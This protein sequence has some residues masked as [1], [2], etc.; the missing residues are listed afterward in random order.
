[1]RRRVC[2]PWHHLLLGYVDYYPNLTYLTLG[3]TYLV[4]RA[5]LYPE[6]TTQLPWLGPPYQATSYYLCLVHVGQPGWSVTPWMK[7]FSFFKKS[8]GSFHGTPCIF[9]SKLHKCGSL[10][11]ISLMLPTVS[12]LLNWSRA[13]TL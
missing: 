11:L 7:L 2:L 13:F 5:V 3:V 12:L 10:L 6:S 8:R 9:G 4:S 1:M